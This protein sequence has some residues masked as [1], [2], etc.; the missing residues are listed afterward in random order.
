MVDILPVGDKALPMLRSLNAFAGHAMFFVLLLPF[1]YYSSALFWQL[2]YPEGF[3][4]SVVKASP[5]EKRVSNKQ[6][7]RTWSW[8]RDT[9]PAPVVQEA[10][11]SK[12]DAQLVGVISKGDGTGIAMI[13]VKRADSK[14]F[15]VGDEV[16]NAVF[17]DSVYSD[18]VTLRR[19]DQFEVLALKR[20]GGEREEAKPE[21]KR[22]PAPAKPVAAKKPKKPVK[23]A[24]ADEYKKLIR[25]KPIRLIEMVEFKRY[26]D[27]DHGFGFELNPRE[28]AHQ[29]L[30]DGL[31]LVPGD[32]LLS[33]NEAKSDKL[34]MSPKTWKALLRAKQIKLKVLRG[35]A[36]QEVTIEE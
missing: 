16:A 1:F 28:E 24:N 19:D 4:P 36:V 11:E 32:V 21:P 15:R 12:L 6:V 7:A 10:Q 25:E 29:A 23:A 27:K 35:G 13:K 14:L 8:F 5:G 26:E 31:G 33:A 34:A 22:K 3:S 30:F 20:L 18:H 17:L 2:A 9:T